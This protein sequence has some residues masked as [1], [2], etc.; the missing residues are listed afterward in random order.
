MIVWV[1]MRMLLLV[2]IAFTL[3][4]PMVVHAAS[5]GII[6]VTQVYTYSLNGEI[7]E[8]TYYELKSV[9][10][11]LPP[12]S[13][14]VIYMKTPG[15]LLD[16]ALNIVSLFE[17]S[18]IVTVGFVYPTGSY[19]WSGGTLVL[20]STTV[21]AMAPGTVIGSCQ[22]VEINEVT[23]QEIF[24][25]EPKILNAV[26]KYFV[27]AAE[28]RGRNTTFAASCVYNDT[29]LGP[30]EALK[31][32]VINYV[33]SS[34]DQLLSVMNGTVVNVNGVN[35][36]LVMENPVVTQLTPPISYQLYDA[37]QSSV[38]ENIISI[39]GVLLILAGLLTAHVYLAGIGAVLLVVLALLGL[40]INY[41]GLGLMVV[42]AL[43]MAFEWHSG[44]KLHGVLIAVG[45]VLIAVG[46]TL[47]IPSVSP[48]QYALKYNP[49]TLRVILYSEIA[50]IG[51][52]SA[53]IVMLIAR[54]IR[55]KPISTVMYYPTA[56]LIG[57]ATEDIKTGQMGIVKIRGEY[58]KAIALE[59]IKEGDRVTVVSY[60]GNIIKVRKAT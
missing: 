8:N 11:Q 2:L 3:M 29:N 44:G 9:I 37:L 16:A 52:L 43:L 27:E 51:G 50:G 55:A 46:L 26:A 31:Y 30:E 60:E 36:T 10:D 21:A 17:T 28:F 14:L 19:A 12:G 54:A 18:S 13:V 58:W 35:Y 59:D 24:I 39:L 38:M 41:A 15:G 34:I 47:L 32:H 4:L 5:N 22:P 6:K 42:G 33:A 53:W 45:A 23:G 48:P 56:G 49:T 1:K 40:P 20:L 25:T 7:T 57:V